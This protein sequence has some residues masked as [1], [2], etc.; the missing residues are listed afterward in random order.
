MKF[1]QLYRRR[2]WIEGK[3]KEKIKEKE[4]RRE[5]EVLGKGL[6]LA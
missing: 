2:M 5:S 4:E 1:H 3:K 6:Y